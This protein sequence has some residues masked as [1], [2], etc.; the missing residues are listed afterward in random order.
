[1]TTI[2]QLIQTSPAKANE[3]L[4][5]L[6]D[7]SDTAVK[8]R[9]RLFSEL[10]V[11]IEQ[12]AR[13][14]E[15]HLFPVLKKHRDTKKLAVEAIKDN[16]QTRKLLADLVRTPKDSEEFA[17][18]VAGLRK[19]FQQHVRDEKN[20]LL[21]AIL[22]ALSD[23]ET[24]A[25]VEKIESKRSEMKATRRADAGR[26]AEARREREEVEAAEQAAENIAIT[27]RAGTD[28][29]RQMARTTQDAVQHD[30]G[31]ATDVAQRSMGQLMELFGLAGQQTQER[32]GQATT[33]AQAMA[34][35]TE[36]LIRGLQDVSREWLDMSRN[37]FQK[38][39]DGFNAM[40][41]CRSIQDVVAL[42]S[43]LV[44][45]NL[46]MTIENSRRLAEL[47][48]GITDKAARSTSEPGKGAERRKR[49]A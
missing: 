32:A 48:V 7:T 47:S 20:E 6:A 38:N 22:K 16:R 44:R 49:A 43:A 18:K 15:Q 17:T 26:R 4:A 24:A 21:P 12:L 28:S 31:T 13:L 34:Q 40:A 39:L 8:T 2:R 46:E 5:K 25:V 10:K 9:D 42:Q 27:V 35:S 36:V 23:E 37:R 1:M 45:E 41:S 19:V 30:L 11:E 29:A 3:L 14:E 33:T